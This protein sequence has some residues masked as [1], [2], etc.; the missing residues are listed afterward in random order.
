MHILFSG[1]KTKD[2]REGQV[3]ILIAISLGGILLAITSVMGLFMLLQIR[4]ARDIAQSNVASYAADAGFNYGTY[5]FLWGPQIADGTKIPVN[6]TSTDSFGNSLLTQSAA[7]TFA[8]IGSPAITFKYGCKF[9]DA[10]SGN[11][12]DDVECSDSSTTLL[13]AIGQTNAQFRVIQRRFHVGP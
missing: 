9:Y 13:T 10:S 12:P 7:H 6:T 8:F 3:M 4:Q 1:Q 2:K 5:L 11:P